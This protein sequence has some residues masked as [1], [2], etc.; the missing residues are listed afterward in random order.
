MSHRKQEII[1]VEEGWYAVHV[2]LLHT[3]VQ[4]KQWVR[5]YVFWRP[6]D[7]KYLVRCCPQKQ[8]R[9]R[10]RRTERLFHISEAGVFA[11]DIQADPSKKFLNVSFSFL[12]KPLMFK[13]LWASYTTLDPK[14]LMKGWNHGN[15]IHTPIFF[16]PFC[17]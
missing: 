9:K 10:R 7:M 1:E 12:S 16:L 2:T 11:Q 6:A 8:T 14:F 13:A 17:M 3:D 4:G 5:M 15:R